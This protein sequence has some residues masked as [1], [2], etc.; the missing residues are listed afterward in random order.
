MTKNIDFFKRQHH[1]NKYNE[2]EVNARTDPT[3]MWAALKKL[4]YFPDTKAALEIVREDKT[5]SNDVHK[6]L[7]RWFRD[8]SRLF[9]GLQE[10][11]EVVFDETFYQEVLEKKQQFENL[12]KEQ[13]DSEEDSEEDYDSSEL[14][15]DIG[16]A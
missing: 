10:D 15:V 6:V 4:N 3:A 7:E 14:N 11:P 16:Y 1:K 8:I 2:L 5:I 9:S 12:E 13:E